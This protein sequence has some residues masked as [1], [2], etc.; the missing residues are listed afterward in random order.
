MPNPRRFLIVDDV[1]DSRALVVRTL[2]RKFPS[3]VIQECQ[4][5]TSALHVAGTDR[6]DCII[7]HRAFELDGITLVRML[8]T[9][10][11]ATPLVMI[12][13]I[14][15]SQEALAAGAT[16]FHNYDEWLRIGTVISEML[17]ARQPPATPPPANKEPDNT[18]GAG[19]S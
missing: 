6:L 5:P 14:D 15:R 12:S 7:A 3:A 2:L 19:V 17:L 18:V 16:V 9:V 1:A 11:P 13:G 8:R 4:E 10:N